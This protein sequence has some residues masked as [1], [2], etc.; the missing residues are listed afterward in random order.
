MQLLLYPIVVMSMGEP[1]DDLWELMGKAR[2]VEAPP[3]FTDR[4]L[5]EVEKAEQTATPTRWEGLLRWWAPA[6]IGTMVAASLLFVFVGEFSKT[7]PGQ[8]NVNPGI[9]AVLPTSPKSP[10]VIVLEKHRVVSAAQITN[11]SSVSETSLSAATNITGGSRTFL[12]VEAVPVSFGGHSP[13]D[14]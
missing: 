11:I 12:N 6:S 4:I 5:R 3:W 13:F 10:V 8:P 9:A 7:Q 1:K 14:P 2:K